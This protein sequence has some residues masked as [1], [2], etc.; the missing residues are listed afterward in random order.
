MNIWTDAGTC[1]TS[2]SQKPFTIADME[3]AAALVALVGPEPIGEWMRSKGHPPEQWTL[4][5]P[6]K[7]FDFGEPVFLPSYVKRS[8][9][10]NEPV[11][12]SRGN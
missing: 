8:T 12:I 5:V 7:V 2:G 10:I 9:H 6:D 3:R 4:V 1:T 11:F